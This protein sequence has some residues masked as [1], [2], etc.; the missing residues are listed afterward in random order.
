[1]RQAHPATGRPALRTWAAALG[2]ASLLAATCPVAVAADEGRAGPKVEDLIAEAL[3]NSPEIAAAR[4]ERDA[5]EQR[6]KPA[7]ALEDPMLEAGVLNVPTGSWSVR[8][9]DMTMKMLG[10]S[11]KLPFPGK[12]ALRE[13]VAT[14]DA[15]IAAYGYQETVNRVVRDVRVAYADLALAIESNRLV[16]QNKSVLEQLLRIAQSRYAVGQV[17]QA[18]VLKAQTQLSKMVDELLRVERERTMAASDL[19]RALGRQGPLAPWS[20]ATLDLEDANLDE[21]S[22]MRS[23][24]TQRPQLRAL[25]VAVAKAGKSVDLAKAD[26]FPDFDVKLAYGQRDRTPDGIPRDD[27]VSL[28]VGINLPIW[29]ATK[30]GPRV[31]EA[32][33][34]RGQAEEMYQAQRNETLMKL[35]QQAAVARQSASS[36][37]LYRTTIVPQARVTVE[38]AIAAYKVGRV[39]LLTL[40]DSQ[41]A[42]FTYEI[43]LAQ[44]LAAHAKASAEIDLLSG[45]TV[46]TNQQ[47]KPK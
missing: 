25:Q 28:T 5:A 26:Y 22:L 45:R 30:Q 35:R 6:V 42:A 43:E 44:V 14:R 27:M 2:L 23:A 31:A 36:A 3:Q 10:L 19:N 24:E 34:M 21:Q 16:S 37:R 4:R 47:W 46:E 38:A 9:E 17:A 29:R 33:A 11:Q 40:L 8:R 20:I 1:M 18:D 32:L 7:G 12:R 13:A 15:E 41:M 39:D